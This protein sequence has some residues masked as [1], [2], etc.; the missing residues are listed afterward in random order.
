MKARLGAP[1]KAQ[2]FQI[3]GTGYKEKRKKQGSVFGH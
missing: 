1:E 3:M 2:G